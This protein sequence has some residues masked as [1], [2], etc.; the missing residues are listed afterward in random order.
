MEHTVDKSNEVIEIELVTMVGEDGSEVY[1]LEKE[2]FTYAGKE[3]A[4][5]VP[6]ADDSDDFSV[7][8]D[9][10][11]AEEEEGIIARVE[12]EDGKTIFVSPTDEEFDGVLQVIQELETV[13]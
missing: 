10:L 5:L 7:D 6:V 13:D 12:E 11:A 2:H 9:I 8:K 4:M 3:F 1:C